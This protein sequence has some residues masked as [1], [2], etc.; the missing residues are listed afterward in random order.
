[1][2]RVSFT[3][4]LARHVDVPDVEVSGA[5]VRDVLDAVFAANPRLQSYVLDEH[6]TLR[7]HMVVFVDGRA[8][9]DREKL[10][11]RVAE[12]GEVYVMQALSGG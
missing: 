11:D 12:D 10:T 5:T 1:M 7:H 6:G 3:S 2:T 8:I 4:H 9:A